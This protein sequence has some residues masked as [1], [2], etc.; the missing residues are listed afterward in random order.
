M[1]VLCPQRCS[2]AQF[3]SMVSARPHYIY[4]D[5]YQYDYE[6]YTSS[7][8]PVCS[9]TAA[10]AVSASR[11]SPLQQPAKSFDSENSPPS[12]VTQGVARDHVHA[13]RSS[14]AWTIWNLCVG[15][16]GMMNLPIGKGKL[17]I[18]IV[19]SACQN[20]FRLSRQKLRT[21]YLGTG[22]TVAATFFPI[23]YTHS[24]VK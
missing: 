10:V 24:R 4:H 7:S 2:C 23:P 19:N 18:E 15:T 12:R 11:H 16:L 3:G 1:S 13:E 5:T 21:M 17:V 22:A 9:S 14:R 20:G 8:V 6:L